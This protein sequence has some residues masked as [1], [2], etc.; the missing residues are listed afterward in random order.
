MKVRELLPATIVGF[1]CLVAFGQVTFT[2]VYEEDFDA[3]GATGT[4][5]PAGWSGARHAGSGT[6]G[7]LLP[8]GTSTGTSTI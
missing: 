8:L 1:H 4:E 2:G 6:I 7:A 3:L 5:Y